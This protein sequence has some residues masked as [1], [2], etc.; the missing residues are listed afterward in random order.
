MTEEKQDEILEEAKKAQKINEALADVP[1]EIEISGKK[2]KLNRFTIDRIIRIDAAILEVSSIID[3][4]SQM[5]SDLETGEK[6]FDE[7]KADLIQ[8]G[9]QLADKLCEVLALILFPDGDLEAN[10]TWVKSNVDLTPDGEGMQ[11]IKLYQSRCSLTP[12]LQ[13]VLAS[14][15]F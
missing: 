2:F 9:T 1:L 11:V 3:R 12:F 13:A 15:Q 4:Y 5:R 8:A 14:K 6:T 10:K 7:L